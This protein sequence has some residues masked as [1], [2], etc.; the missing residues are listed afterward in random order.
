MGRHRSRQ[1]FSCPLPGRLGQLRPEGSWLSRWHAACSVEVPHQLRHRHRQLHALHS[2]LGEGPGLPDSVLR[3]GEFRPDEGKVCLCH[4]GSCKHAEGPRDQWTHPGGLHG[5]KSFM[6]YHSDIYHKHRS[7]KQPEGGH[8]VKLVGWGTESGKK[9]WL[10]AN[11]WDTTWGEEGFFRIISGK[12]ECG[13]ET[14]GPPYAGL[15]AVG[16]EDLIVV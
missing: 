5:Y 6:T 13:I 12:D 16:H 8:A 15:P 3:F 2:W 7:E 9:Y 10:I 4:P 11:S 1:G 14:M